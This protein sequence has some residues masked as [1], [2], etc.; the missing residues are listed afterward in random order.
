MRNLVFSLVL[1][2]IS[3]FSVSTAHATIFWEEDFEQTLQAHGWDTSSCGNGTSITPRGSFTTS[4][5]PNGCN[6][7]RSTELPHNGQYSLKS[8]YTA[9][10]AYL[11]DN[12]SGTCV[13]FYDRYQQP[14]T[15]VWTRFYVRW[16]ADWGAPQNSNADG[17]KIF[18][19]RDSVH[20][21]PEI[22]WTSM[23]YAYDIK[24]TT[25]A[26]FELC[27]SNGFGPYDSCDYKTSFSP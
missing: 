2:I 3:V 22:F 1:V 7:F 19:N 9:P 15:D 24:G 6:G 4:A 16:S 11:G 20:G 17:S 23:F 10:N 5:W 14:S 13:T 27:P 25:V 12:T 21:N 26:D 18:Y 8:D